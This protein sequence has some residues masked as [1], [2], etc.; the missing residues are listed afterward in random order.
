MNGAVNDSMR[1]DGIGGFVG[2]QFYGLGCPT[3]D[4]DV[5]EIARM[6]LLSGHSYRTARQPSFEET[7]CLH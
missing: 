4:V 1:L 6:R 7:R 5:I 2:N 3:A